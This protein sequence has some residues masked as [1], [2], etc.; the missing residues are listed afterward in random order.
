[1]MTV[2]PVAISNLSLL[3]N[4]GQTPIKCNFAAW[5]EGGEVRFTLW[6]EYL[7]F[8]NTKFYYNF[9]A[10]HHLC[11]WAQVQ[12]DITRHSGGY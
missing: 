11:R 8:V 1:M 6:Q 12:I 9:G 10:A 2:L 7:L 4:D 3:L 5:R